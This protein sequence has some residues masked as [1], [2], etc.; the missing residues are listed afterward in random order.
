[1]HRYLYILGRPVESDFYVNKSFYDNL[2]WLFLELIDRSSLHSIHFFSTTLVY[3]GIDHVK[4]SAST[5]VKPYSFYEYFKLDFELFLQYL[6]LNFCQ[7]T[8]IYIYRLPLLF[9][10][11]F[12]WKKN[13]DQFIYYFIASYAQSNGWVFKSNKDKQYGTSWASTSD[14]CQFIKTNHNEPGFYL[15]NASS[16]FFSYFELDQILSNYFGKPKNNDLKLYHSYFRIDDEL[17][18]PARDI[19]NSFLNLDISKLIDEK[20]I[21]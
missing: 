16:G 15:K 5:I 8:A 21:V 20:P 14:L 10:G 19:K 3:S 6:S 18:L 1:M 11:K 13:S 4:S 9:D 12:S 7:D 2:K 17:G